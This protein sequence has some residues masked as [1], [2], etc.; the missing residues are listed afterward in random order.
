MVLLKDRGAVNAL[1]AC[2]CSG[3]PQ[4]RRT[5]SPSQAIRKAESES[6]A[7]PS[8]TVPQG[9][10]ATRSGRLLAPRQPL[11]CLLTYFISLQRDRQ[12]IL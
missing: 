8:V 11:H 5:D 2:V 1:A 3:V 6:Q 4:P 9:G 10:E 12:S 7:F